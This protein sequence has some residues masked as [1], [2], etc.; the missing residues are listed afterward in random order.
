MRMHPECRFS[1][2]LDIDKLT[3]IRKIK[4]E[5]FGFSTLLDIDKLTLSAAA[6]AVL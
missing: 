6:A 1:T 4:R 3:L 5:W 2:L